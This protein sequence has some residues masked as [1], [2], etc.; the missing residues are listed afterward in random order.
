MNYIEL[1]NVSKSFDGKTILSDINLSVA[2]GESI[3][4]IGGSGSGKTVLMKMMAGLLTPTC[5][6]INVAGFDLCKSQNLE[7]FM[8]KIGYLFQLNALFDS[9]PIWKNIALSLIVRQGISKE[10]AKQIAVES[11]KQVDLDPNI[12]NL[13]PSD[14]SGGMQKRV[15]LARCLA[16]KP[17]IIFFDEPTSGLDPLT[18][19]KIANL[20]ANIGHNDTTKKITKI[21]IMHD[22]KCTQIVADKVLYLLNGKIEWFGKS[23]DLNNSGNENL[24]LFFKAAHI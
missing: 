19:I 12:L 11:L 15:S 5:G 9:Y 13:Y 3:V 4:I 17:E 10:T 2:Q 6:D 22:M 24:D 16:S 20:I 14:I 8:L 1:K 7:N 21:S 18:S 23:D